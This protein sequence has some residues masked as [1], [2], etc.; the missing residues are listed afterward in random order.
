MGKLESVDA[1][2]VTEMDGAD[3]EETFTELRAGDTVH[4][5]GW[6]GGNTYVE[7][8]GTVSDERHT[9]DETDDVVW[10]DDGVSLR[11][12]WMPAEPSVGIERPYPEPPIQLDAEE[13]YDVVRIDAN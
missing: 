12:Q 3:L 4:V 6:G 5:I 13:R 7:Y 11:L 9:H 2:D 10:C 1:T 8:R